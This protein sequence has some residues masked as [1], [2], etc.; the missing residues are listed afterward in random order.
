MQYNLRNA[1]K[2]NNIKTYEL[3]FLCEESGMPTNLKVTG[4]GLASCEYGQKETRYQECVIYL[5]NGQF[6][7]A[8]VDMQT[9]KGTYRFS[10]TLEG[11]GEMDFLLREKAK[12]SI[13]YKF[14]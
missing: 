7:H 12:D 2:N 3:D 5:D 6:F 11:L 14:L 1:A 13:T 4:V 10:D 8:Y 9:E